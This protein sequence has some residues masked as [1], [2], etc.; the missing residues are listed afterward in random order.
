MV[1]WVSQNIYMYMYFY[2]HHYLSLSLSSVCPFGSMFLSDSCHESSDL[3]TAL[4]F[5]IY[6]FSVF[7][8]V[9]G[10]DLF[11]YFDWEGSCSRNAAYFWNHSLIFL[12]SQF[13]TATTFSIN[14]RKLSSFPFSTS[15]CFSYLFRPFV[16]FL[17]AELIKG[18][19]AI[20]SQDK[21]LFSH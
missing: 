7:K 17:L 2:F 3:M 18:D 12:F 5:H 1:G 9:S 19:F 11:M 14:N 4:Y 8:Q 21:R 13:N 16:W 6:C 15:L 10:V 20:S